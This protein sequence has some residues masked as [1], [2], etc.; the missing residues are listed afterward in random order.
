MENITEK[1]MDM[2][3]KCPKDDDELLGCVSDL[4][5]QYY[6]LQD[7]AEK[8]QREMDQVQFKLNSQCVNFKN[9]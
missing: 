1:G 5:Q 3:T 4:Q 9:E 6:K 8:M 7:N 2:S